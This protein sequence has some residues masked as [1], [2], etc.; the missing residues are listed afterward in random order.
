VNWEGAIY[1]YYNYNLL[2]AE[3]WKELGGHYIIICKKEWY[4]DYWM[5]RQSV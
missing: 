3:T 1:H 5:L 4:N 2:K